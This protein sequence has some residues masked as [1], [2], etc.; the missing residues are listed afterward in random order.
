MAVTRQLKLIMEDLKEQLRHTSIKNIDIPQ[1]FH[2]Y[3]ESLQHFVTLVYHPQR[4]E[5]SL[6]TIHSYI[7]YINKQ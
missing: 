6:G 1:I 5:E 2:F 3:P 7:I 4:S